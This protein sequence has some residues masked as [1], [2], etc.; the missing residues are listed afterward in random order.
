MLGTKGA[1]ALAAKVRVQRTEKEMVPTTI[2]E[3]R[4]L[5]AHLDPHQIESLDAA[6]ALGPTIPDPF[7][8][9][10]VVA[11]EMEGDLAA[12]IGYYEQALERSPPEPMVDVIEGVISEMRAALEASG[13]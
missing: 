10:G 2:P 4:I 7:M 11:R 6:I 13:S 12:A 3:L 1:G 8:F 9:R 5:S